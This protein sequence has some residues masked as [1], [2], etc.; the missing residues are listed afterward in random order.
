MSNKTNQRFEELDALRGI[1]V[2]SVVL[3]HYTNKY[4]VFF[5][6]NS[7]V[8]SG[9]YIGEYGVPLFF[10][11]SGFVIYLTVNNCKNA[12]DFAWR[13][14]TRLY[15]IFWICV[16]LTFFGV[17]YANTLPEL[18]SNWLDGL[19]NLTMFYRPLRYFIDIK[20]VDGAYW[21]LLP[22]LQFYLLIF[23][24]MLFNKMKYIKGVS[25]IWLLLVIVENYMFHIP[26]IGSFINLYFG[27][28]FI[29]GILFFRIRVYNEH[30]LVNH[31]F[32]LC[33]LIINIIIY[34]TL[35]HPHPFLILPIIYVVFYLFIYGKLKFINN[36]VLL[37]LGAISYPL[38][39]LHQNLGYVLIYQLRSYGYSS[40]IIVPFVTI[41]FIM[42][43]A[44][45][46]FYIERPFLKLLRN[47][48][49]FK[50]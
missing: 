23:S 38:Y 15:P 25:L 43:A 9:F 18:K 24:L 17:N 30:T 49:P 27:G 22:E 4:D 48:T 5:T 20:D 37:F 50:K 11:I 8:F 35:N 41:V 29:A 32:I 19:F 12:Y 6:P 34:N 3:F 46:T 7:S 26:I 1:A 44:F 39:L 21:S 10:I 28:F 33:T 14:F 13:R 45:L 16:I 47:F 2:M 42:L 31:L 36:K 40:Y